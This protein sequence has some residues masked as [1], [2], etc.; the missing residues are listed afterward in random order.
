MRS[1]I[2]ASVIAAAFAGSA[3]AQTATP[4]A[5]AKP[6]APPMAAPA[7]PAAAPAKPMA[8]AP[9]AAL[10]DINSATKPE[11]MALKG[12]GDVRADGII[13]GRPY[14]GKDDLVQKNIVPKAVYDDI[15]DK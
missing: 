5:P 2:L 7:K 14:K 15:K 11:L 1:F 3:F 9:R 8:A 4:A 6:A 12:I 10:L 13:K